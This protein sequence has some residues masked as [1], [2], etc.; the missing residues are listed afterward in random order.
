MLRMVERRSRK[1]LFILLVRIGTFVPVAY[2]ERF[3]PVA[4][5]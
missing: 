3:F 2:D 1:Y 4:A 5:N